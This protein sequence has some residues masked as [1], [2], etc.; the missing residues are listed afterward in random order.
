[1][2][3]WVI[4]KSP[5]A[6]MAL[7]K[8]FI[9]SEFNPVMERVTGLNQAEVLGKHYLEV[10]PGL[11]VRHKSILFVFFNFLFTTFVESIF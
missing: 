6:V 4:S 5:D 7:D 10:F 11:Q 8:D 1:M 9:F 2:T 3:S